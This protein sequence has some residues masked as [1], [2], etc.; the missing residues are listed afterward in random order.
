MKDESQALAED[1]KIYSNGLILAL[2]Q[3]KI[4]EGIECVNKMTLHL[5]KVKQ[6]LEM[7]KSIPDD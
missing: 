4:Q 3:G 5:E 1:I 7:K 2:E 6:Y